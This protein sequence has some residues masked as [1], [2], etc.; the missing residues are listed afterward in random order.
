ME[1]WKV[2]QEVYHRLREN[3]DSDDLNKKD[4]VMS[5][6]IVEEAIDYFYTKN[7]GWIYP[8]KSYMVGICYSKWLS[9]RFGETPFYYLDNPSLLYVND[10]FFVPYSEGKESYDK[11]LEKVTWDFEKESGMVSDVWC[12]F[13]EE[14]LLNE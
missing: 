4:I 13:M 6:N 1:D 12:Y 11:I 7:K 9:E 10:P 3:T 14:F 8:A 2:R 5:E